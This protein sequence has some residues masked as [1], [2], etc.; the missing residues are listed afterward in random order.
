MDNLFP[1]A[2]LASQGVSGQKVAMI[3]FN[4]VKKILVIQTGDLGDVVWMTPALSAVKAACPQAGVS[5][6]LRGGSGGIFE[7]GT[8]GRSLGKIS[9]PTPFSPAFSP[10]AVRYGDSPPSSWR[11]AYNGPAFR[12]A[13]QGG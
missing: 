4:N 1:V 6:L 10:P 3:L 11:R 8:P 2:A 5:L 12:G 13:D 9:G 7:G